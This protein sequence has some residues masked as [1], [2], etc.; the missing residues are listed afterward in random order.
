MSGD[1]PSVRD[2]LRSG[3]ARLRQAG[4]GTPELDAA[5]LLAHSLGV[6]RASLY[7]RALE[8]IPPDARARFTAALTQRARGIPVA[9]LTGTKE[10]IE[11]GVHG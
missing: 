11:S 4:G 6:S 1:V 9:Y 3:A 7:A 8:S 10:F 2:L 5:V